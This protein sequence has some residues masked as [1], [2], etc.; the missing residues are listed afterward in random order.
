MAHKKKGQV[1]CQ[2]SELEDLSSKSFSVK[3]KRKKTDIFVIRKDDQVYAYQNVCPHA[4][5]PLEWNPDEFLDA[6]KENIICALH[7]AIFSI[8]GGGCLG[9][10]CE[11][12]G[13]T[14][15]PVEVQEGEIVV[16][17]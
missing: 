2:L 16:I 1:L 3:I 14:A 17:S 6:E 11:G 13:L 9:G 5:A 7:G 15:V 12:I 8:E 4:Q 10:P